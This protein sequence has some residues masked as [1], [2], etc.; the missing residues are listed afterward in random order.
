MN[1]A[2]YKLSKYNTNKQ[3]SGSACMDFQG[4]NR[5]SLDAPHEVP[6]REHGL[7]QS[8]F[9][10]LTGTIPKWGRTLAEASPVTPG[11]SHST[12]SNLGGGIQ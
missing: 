10:S 5:Q 7:A 9:G 2:Y 6:Q 8:S 3:L 4:Y 11:Y 12:M 1:K